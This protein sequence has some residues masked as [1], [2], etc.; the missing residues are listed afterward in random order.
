MKV[1]R[2]QSKVE[3]YW[4]LR[5]G[6][7]L[8]HIVSHINGTLLMY[9]DIKLLD[10]APSDYEKTLLEQYATKHGETYNEGWLNDKIINNFLI[11]VQRKSQGT[12][13][14]AVMS[15]FMYTKLCKYGVHSITKWIQKNPF[16]KADLCFI[17]INWTIITGVLGLLIAHL[18]AICPEM[19]P[20]DVKYF[21]NSTKFD[22]DNLMEVHVGFLYAWKYMAVR[23]ANPQKNVQIPIRKQTEHCNEDDHATYTLKAKV[24]NILSLSDDGLESV[25]KEVLNEGDKGF[26][27]ISLVC[28]RFRQ[29]V[30]RDSFRR[31]THF[32]W[33]NSVWE[34]NS[35]SKEF[36]EENYK[37]YEIKTCFQCGMSFK[38]MYGFIGNG[39]YGEFRKF[40]ST[41]E[42]PGFCS[43][44]CIK[45]S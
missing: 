39:K 6:H 5:K 32:A 38:E 2:Y 28:K 17:P 15:S 25:F 12:N 41:L 3:R 37:M 1:H 30:G 16:F 40:Y 34:W 31:T 33:L 45:E 10:Q 14:V 8:H 4:D 21:D 7:Q 11:D 23:L 29:I 20:P 13:R 27:T 24:R 44:E 18:Q 36:K 22:P 43:K 9:Y 42:Y 26:L 35:S 19:S